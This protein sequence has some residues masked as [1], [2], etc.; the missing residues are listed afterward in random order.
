M[1]TWYSQA[2]NGNIQGL[3]GGTPDGI[4]TNNP[5]GLSPPIPVDKSAW[6]GSAGK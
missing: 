2:R 4:A 3:L 5:T 1:N 6:S